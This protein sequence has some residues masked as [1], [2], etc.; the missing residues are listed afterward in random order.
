MYGWLITGNQTPIVWDRFLDPGY[1]TNSG[2]YSVELELRV[3]LGLNIKERKL[4]DAQK[5][6]VQSAEVNLQSTWMQIDNYL[7]ATRKRIS[8]LVKTLRNAS[9]VVEYRA[10]L[11]DAEIGRQRAGKSTFRKIFEIE[12]EL[13]KSL[14]WQ[15]E[16]VLDFRSSRAQA[17]RLMGTMLIEK[18]LE[19]F[20]N[21][22]HAFRGPLADPQR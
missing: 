17:S 9:I 10:T 1:R 6:N 5:R 8:D 22:V 14:Q 12:E 13:T 11:L 21:G 20:E 16:N 18:D 2:T 4:L 15:M 7:S 3:P 19:S